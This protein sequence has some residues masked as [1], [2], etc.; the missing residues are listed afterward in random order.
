[1]N[2]NWNSA[3]QWILFFY[4]S[5]GFYP[6]SLRAEDLRI[7]VASNFLKASQ[8]L[9]QQFELQSQHKIQISSGSSGK[10]FLQISK[11]A[12]FDLFLSADTQKPQELVKKDLAQ[13]DSLQTY[14]LGKLVLWLRACHTPLD[15]SQLLNNKVKKIA[16]ANPK[17]APYGFASKQLLINNQLWHR[18]ESKLVFPENISQVSQLVKIGVVDAAFIA[19]SHKSQLNTDGQNCVI[20]IPT[21]DYPAIEQQLV[22]ISGS[23]HKSVANEFIDFMLSNTG[24]DLIK[25]MEYLLPDSGKISP[26]E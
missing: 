16:M 26:L 21:T 2:F 4:L 15:L 17:L 1:M 22:I 11:G 5:V 20:D 6:N 3:F 8:D 24:Q 18:L 7:A 12:P 13:A 23:P 10:L 14:A 9:A 19:A 25:N